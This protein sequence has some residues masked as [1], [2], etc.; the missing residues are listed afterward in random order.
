MDRSDV[1]AL[2]V[3]ILIAGVIWLLRSLTENATDIIQV[4]VAYQLQDDQT[5]LVSADTEYLEVEVNSTGFGILGQRYFKRERAVDV[6]I[7][8]SVY[9]TGRSALETSRLRS[10]LLR[11]VGNDRNIVAIRP[12][13]LR[14][15]LS[16]MNQRTIPVMV[17]FKLTN[18]DQNKLKSQLRPIPSEVVLEG[19]S[20]I[21]DTMH[22]V[23]T[24]VLTIDGNGEQELALNLPQGVN[25]SAESVSVSWSTDRLINASIIVDI[26]APKISGVKSISF[27]P[28]SVKVGFISAGSM[29]EAFSPDDFKV[30]CDT[31]SLTELAESGKQRVALRLEQYPPG[32]K[33]LVIEPGRVEFLIIR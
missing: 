13:S 1:R 18:P 2:I 12:D 30:V 25:A 20:L 4:P 21:L 7:D 14:F 22:F 3:C 11:I 5:K 29:A 15:M 8:A 27:F 10:E 33:D 32:L 6:P 26:T 17:D 28:D 23:H 24:E 9:G 31:E 16:T 19:P